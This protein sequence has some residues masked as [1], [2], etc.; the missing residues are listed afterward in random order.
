MTNKVW[1]TRMSEMREEL[2]HWLLEISG[3]GEKKGK[4]TIMRE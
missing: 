4:P 2:D 3:Y 1:E